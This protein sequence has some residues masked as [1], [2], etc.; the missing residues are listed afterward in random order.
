MSRNGSG[1]YTKV[2]TFVSGNPV[3]A[4]GHNQNWDDLATEMTN[5]VAADGQTSMTGPF[6]ASTGSVGWSLRPY[7]PSTAMRISME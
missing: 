1:V 5:S 4:A 7:R 2:N 6:K 3:T